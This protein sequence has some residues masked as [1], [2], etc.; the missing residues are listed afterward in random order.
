MNKIFYSSMFRVSIIF[1][2]SVFILGLSFANFQIKKDKLF[3]LKFYFKKPLIRLKSTFIILLLFLFI[4]YVFL[5]KT[6]SLD[7]VVKSYLSYLIYYQ[8]IIDSGLVLF[9]ISLFLSILNLILS[10]VL[11]CLSTISSSFW[12]FFFVFSCF[13]IFLIVF[14]L[15][16]INTLKHNSSKHLFSLVLFQFRRSK[17]LDK[18]I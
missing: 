1:A 15:L 10:L 18:T 4:G 12:V 9:K 5:F 14:Y 13:E 3:N 11:V 6:I 8:N 17:K 16:K 2:I 7:D